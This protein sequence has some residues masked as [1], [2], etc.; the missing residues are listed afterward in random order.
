MSWVLN[1]TPPAAKAVQTHMVHF[2]VA[3]YIIQY[4]HIAKSQIRSFFQKS[5]FIERY[6]YN[7]P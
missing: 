7:A 3:H 1:L 4:E 6:N 2:S 5:S